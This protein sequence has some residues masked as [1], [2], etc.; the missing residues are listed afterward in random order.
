[1]ALTRT[2]F[3]A[4]PFK[5]GWKRA[6]CN[7]FSKIQK[8]IAIFNGKRTHVAQNANFI[9]VNAIKIQSIREKNYRK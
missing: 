7:A 3:V 6:K 9:P 5:Y 2:H 8:K 4:V 1:M